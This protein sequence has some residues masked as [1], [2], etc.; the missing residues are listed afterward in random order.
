[1]TYPKGYTKGAVSKYYLDAAPL[2]C[3]ALGR[4]PTTLGSRAAVCGARVW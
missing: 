2:V 4:L 1:M 3:R